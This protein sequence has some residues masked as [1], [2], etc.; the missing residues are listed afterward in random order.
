M[1]VCFFSTVYGQNPKAEVPPPVTITLEKPEGY[2]YLPLALE[3]PPIPDESN[4]YHL[5]TIN[6]FEAYKENRLLVFDLNYLKEENAQLRKKIEEL[7]TQL[8]ERS[9]IAAQN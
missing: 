3:V 8:K 2:V 6:L 9:K 4:P 5:V 1:M 7:E